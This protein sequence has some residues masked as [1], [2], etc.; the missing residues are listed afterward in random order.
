MQ[1]YLLREESLSIG[2]YN[3]FLGNAKLPTETGNCLIFQ[4]RIE[5]LN[6]YVVSC[7]EIVNEFNYL[8]N[9]FYICIRDARNMYLPKYHIINPN[10]SKFE[11]LF[12]LIN[13]NKLTKTS[14]FINAIIERV[15]SFG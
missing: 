13:K 3:I 8:F 5:Y 15:S 4:K 14:K 11:I 12:N 7:N 9:C 10:V 1:N 2:V 6:Y